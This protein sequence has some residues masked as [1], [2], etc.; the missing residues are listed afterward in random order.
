MTMDPIPIYLRER[1][2]AAVEGGESVADVAA[3]F[4]I[5]DQTVRNFLK[6]AEEGE[7]EPK[8]R[9]GGPRPKLDDQDRQNLVEAV[10]ENPD[11]T[12]EELIE[13][14]DLDVSD[15]TV[16]RELQRLDRPRKRK[17]P[18]A[19][20]QD[21]KKKQQ[22]R[23]AWRAKT[24]DVDP[25]R[26]IFVDETGI[27]TKMTRRYG[28]APANQRLFTDVPYRHYQNL[29]VLGGLR[30]GGS[31]EIPT[32]VYEGGTTTERMLEYIHGPLA[33]VL[34]PNDIIVADNLAAHKANKVA[35]ALR[36]YEA[37]IWLLPPYSPDLNPIE[38]LWSKIKTSLRQ[39]KATTVET[40]TQ[41]AHRAL[42]T[43][44]NTDIRGWI[45]HSHYLQAA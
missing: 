39:A 8:P 38:R 29:T 18:R 21:E 5:S 30:L 42:K 16:S 27:S 1:I 33:A 14:C 45:S 11:A 31:E 6:R 44:T 35:A 17:V 34:R 15:S 7:L 12:L 32:L 19:S 40:L 24:K 20:E 10:D 13:T 41:A 43:I 36:E 9:S 28:R 3:R 2:V 22:Q 26:L 37:D 4:E 25:K 23:R